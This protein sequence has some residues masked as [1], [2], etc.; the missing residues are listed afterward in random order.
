MGRT[1]SP[2]ENWNTKEG[3][4]GFLEREK[5]KELERKG[6]GSVRDHQTENTT[7]KRVATW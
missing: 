4:T 1:S 2:I 3:E 7:E 6:D 5:E